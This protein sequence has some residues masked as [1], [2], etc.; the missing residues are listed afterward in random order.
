M[1]VREYTNAIRG[2]AA[3]APSAGMMNEHQLRL[4]QLGRGRKEATGRN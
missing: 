3:K 4:R 1:Q 2:A